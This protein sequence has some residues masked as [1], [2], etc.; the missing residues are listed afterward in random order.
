MAGVSESQDL[1]AFIREQSLLSERRSQRL[2]EQFMAELREYREAMHRHFDK[3]DRK[4]DDLL[5]ENRAQRE[6]LFR[7]MD[8]LDGGGAAPA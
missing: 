1:R 7:M 2:H 6:A 5:A 8:K 3:Q 4:L